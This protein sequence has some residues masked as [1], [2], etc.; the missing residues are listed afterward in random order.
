MNKV[1]SEHG[2]GLSAELLHVSQRF[3]LRVVGHDARPSTY[4]I[5]LREPTKHSRHSYSATTNQFT[6]KQ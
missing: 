2:V 3:G 6:R 5:A 1:G 4:A